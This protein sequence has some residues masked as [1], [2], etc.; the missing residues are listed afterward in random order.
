MAE[1]APRKAVGKKY[2]GFTYETEGEWKGSFCFIHAADTQFGLIDS[3]NE[4]PPE[5]QAWE[6]E[7]VLTRKAISAANKL[8]PKPRFF[9]VCGDLVNA[10][11]CEKFN[12]PQVEDF[13]RIFKELDTSIPLVC[14]CGNHDIGD[15]PTQQSLEKY[16]SNFGDDFYSFWVGGNL[17]SYLFILCFFVV[18]N[19][20][21]LFCRK[22][23]NPFA[24]IKGFPY[25][26]Y[27]F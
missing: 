24:I 20:L 27:F 6:K 2:P 23:N 22:G 7:I 1:G 16:K 4:V 21:D 26:V 13:K 18:A 10:F 9:V 19:L 3:W 11:P 5:E 17:S 15:S 14:V 8:S 25:L 12:D